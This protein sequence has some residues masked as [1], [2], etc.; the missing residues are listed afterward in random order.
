MLNGNVNR[1]I[2]VHSILASFLN[3]YGNSEQKVFVSKFM[4]FSYSFAQHVNFNCSIIY[5]LYESM[6]EANAIDMP[7]CFCIVIC[8]A[9]C[10]PNY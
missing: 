8:H 3:R 9:F 4:V 6:R 5:F 7:T 10:V 1:L 2:I